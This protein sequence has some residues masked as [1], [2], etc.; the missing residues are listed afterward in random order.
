MKEL[1]KYVM[2]LYDLAKSPCSEAKSRDEEILMDSLATQQM[3]FKASAFVNLRVHLLQ[4]T[5]W[6]RTSRPK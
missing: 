1:D 4:L 6:C 3:D 5:T 2:S